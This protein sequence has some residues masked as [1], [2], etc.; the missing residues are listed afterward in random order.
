[1]RLLDRIAAA[2]TVFGV[3]M[4]LGACSTHARERAG[5]DA[6][7]TVVNGPSADYPMI[8]GEPFEIEGVKYVPADVMNYDHVG[9]AAIDGES[10]IGVTAADRI[11]PLPSYVEVTALDSGRTILVRV[12]RR[13]PMTNERLVALSPTAMAQ[14]GIADG[15]PVRMRRVNPPEEMRAKLRAGQEASPRMDTP[16]GLLVVLRKKLP[17]AGSVSLADPRQTQV[18]GSVPAA[19]AI[20]SIDPTPPAG[21]ASVEVVA[22]VDAQ[23][24]ASSPSADE[25]G[26]ETG[27]FTVQLGAFSVRSN[28]ER[29]AKKVGGFL[30]EAGRLTIVRA[31]HYATRGQAADALAKLQAQGYSD[32]EIR[33][34]D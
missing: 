8:I 7:P 3:A 31:G 4:T 16:E 20:Q 29:L 25:L 32:A 33:T 28:A 30:V 5:V 34:L 14:L 9:Y 22:E 10:T 15:A 24:A 19:D 18:S 11:L 27:K 26:G 6:A 12:E 1:M 17:K 2:A 23:D 21:A 13:G